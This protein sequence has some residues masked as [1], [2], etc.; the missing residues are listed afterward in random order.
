MSEYID[1]VV[2]RFARRAPWAVVCLLAVGLVP[3]EV[4]ADDLPENTTPTTQSRS[5]SVKSAGRLPAVP[6]KLVVLTFD[7]AVKSHFTI[8]AP[9]LKKHKFGATFFITEGFEFKTNKQHYMTWEEVARLHRDGF[10]I[11]NHTR[12]H[13]MLMPRKPEFFKKQLAQFQEQ[14]EHINK[15]CKAHGIPQ[16][17]SFAWPGNGVSEK[18]FP[19]LQKL[20]FKFARRGGEPEYDYKEGRG[21][22]YE[23][24]L[25]HPLL[26]PSAGDARPGWK[27]ADFKR[28]AEQ[29][30]FGHIAVLQFHGVP[31]LAHP[32]VHSPVERFK[33]YM[34]YLADNDYTVVALRDLE[35]YVDPNVEPKDPFGVVNDRKRAIAGNKSRDNFRTPRT[36]DELKSWLQNMVQHHRFTKSEIRAATGLSREKIEAALKRFEIRPDNAPRR[37][38]EDPLLVLPYPGGRHPRIGFRDGMIRPQ[39]ETK[40]SVFLPWD[41]GGYIVLDLPEAIRRNDEQK[42]GL[43]YL[44]HTHVPTMWD[45]RKIELKPLE[46]RRLKA[47]GSQNAGYAMERKLP[48]GV[49]FGTKVR[50]GKRDVQMEMHLT[51][52][53]QE[54]LSGLRVQNCILLAGAPEFAALSNENKVVRPPYAACRS[55]DGKRWIITAWSPNFRTW[56]NPPC[57]CMHS[58]P[59]FPDCKPGE[60]KRLVGRL[61]FYEGTEI[62]KELKR[63]DATGWQQLD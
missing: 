46:W 7:D 39:R 23:P 44:A 27:L 50:P 52:G 63:L 40:L 24:G 42:H 10:E 28:A 59:Q 15:R 58:D 36:D 5:K 34:Q 19:I 14:L 9:I 47:N 8:V 20:G 57:P 54:T 4:R 16:P 11:G 55:K 60:T 22:A 3:A 26:I 12:D 32:W 13:M 56:A 61:W 53:S 25:D 45:K 62:D 17:V 35:K 43:L 51:N 38:P 41:A 21:P 48:N 29:A 1:S 18:A 49:V 37:S 6:D 33:E 2:W 30:K 31:D